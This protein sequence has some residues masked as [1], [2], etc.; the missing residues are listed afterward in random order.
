MAKAALTFVISEISVAD[1]CMAVNLS[2][3]IRPKL[4]TQGV[5]TIWRGEMIIQ[6]KCWVLKVTKLY[7]CRY[8]EIN[9]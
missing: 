6:N 5:I 3:K 2:A 1:K 7:F 4:P 9:W 8:I